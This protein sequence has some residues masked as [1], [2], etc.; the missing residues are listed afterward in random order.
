M[1]KHAIPFVDLRGKNLVDLLRMY[2]DKAEELV[3]AARRTYGPTSYLA[4]AALMPI[5][6]RISRSWLKKSSNPYLSEI[7]SMADVLSCRGVYALNV[8]F[9]WGCTS[10]IWKT[11]ATYSM[12]RVL[13][14]PFPALGR[15]VVVTLQDGKAGEFYNVTWPGVS[16][17]FTAMAPGRFA[18]SIN[19]APMRRHHRG[20]VGD[21]LVNRK[22]AH[23]ETAIP[24]SHLLRHA[25]E[26]A[27]NYSTAKSLLMKT[28]I[29]VPATFILGGIKAGEA[30]VIERLENSAELF[31]ISADYS[32]R[33]T[34]HFNS[35]F[36]SFGKGW[37]PREID[38]HGRYRQ[39]ASIGGHELAQLGFSW[40]QAPI[41]NANTRVCVIADPMTR[42][43]MV[44]GYEGS[45]PV[46]ELFHIPP[47]RYDQQEAV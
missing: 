45:L 10:G 39:S 26:T 42:R 38:S 5:A 35:S 44:Q 30:C 21:W 29:A 11:D 2:P 8:S 3:A 20:F 40:L 31:E 4:S 43:L 6:D 18:A 33:A 27:E 7:E 23:K 12:L 1:L 16:G 47:S 32:I 46:T 25:F 36:A 19:Q 41:I 37:W 9:E 15:H 34:N 14:W 17:V 28:P 24:A 13:D 22:I